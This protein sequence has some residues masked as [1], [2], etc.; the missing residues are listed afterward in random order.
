MRCNLYL[1]IDSFQSSSITA[2]LAAV[3]VAISITCVE[4][5]GFHIHW[6]SADIASNRAYVCIVVGV[7][8]LISASFGES[9]VSKDGWVAFVAADIADSCSLEVYAVL[10]DIVVA[11]EFASVITI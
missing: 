9:L 3:P 1:A 6:D 11:V 2:V 4:F 7:P 8:I 10:T 5:V